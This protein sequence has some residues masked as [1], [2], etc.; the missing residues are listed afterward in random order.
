MTERHVGIGRE[1]VNNGMV[2]GRKDGSA[3]NGVGKF[4]KNC[5]GNGISIVSGSTST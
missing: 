1:L 4:L 3:L 5:C 2:M